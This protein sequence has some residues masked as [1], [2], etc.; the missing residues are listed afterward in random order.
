[1]AGFTFCRELSLDQHLGGDTRMISTHLPECVAAVHALITNQ[2][3]HQRLIE[4]MAHMQ[5]TRNIGR[6]YKNAVGVAVTRG[7]EKVGCL[8]LGVE[9][10]LYLFRIE[11][12]FHSSSGSSL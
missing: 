7:G 1:M 2:C 5:G 8:P 4:C 10:A 9:L 11:A 12:V 3:I 6:W